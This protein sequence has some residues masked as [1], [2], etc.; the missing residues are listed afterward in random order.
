MSFASVTE[1]P[2]N[3]AHCEQIDAMRT[4]YEWAAEMCRG[5]DVVEIACGAGI[6]LGIL[7]RHA[8]SVIGGDLDSKVLA[9]GLEHYKDRNIRLMELDAC[10]MELEDDSVDVAICFEATYYFPSLAVFMR[11]VRRILRPGGLFVLS[12]VNSRWHGFNPS[13][14]SN[15]YHSAGEMREELEEAGFGGDF[16]ACFEDDPATWKRRVIGMVRR[17]AVALRLV[18][19]TMKGKEFFKKLFYGKLEPLPYELSE[20]HGTRRELKPFG[21]GLKPEN[22]KF[23]Y[24]VAKRKGDGPKR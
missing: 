5:K 12:S 10:K 21:T 4:R 9:Y 7:A 17:I 15:Q 8:K 13:P 14:Y 24:F 11:E 1:L 23:F 18:P 3:G 19:Q 2:G 20:A 22:H 6:G 16:F